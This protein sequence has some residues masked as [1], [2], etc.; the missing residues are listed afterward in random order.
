MKMGGATHVGRVVRDGSQVGHRA[1]VRG[2]D[3]REHDER[4]HEQQRNDG[5]LDVMPRQAGDL[6]LGIAEFLLV[7]VGKDTHLL[8]LL[9]EEEP[10]L[11]IGVLWP[12]SPAVFIN[13][14]GR[15][16]R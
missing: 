2:L 8:A 4:H 7:L 15:D 12:L 16:E 14:I 9:V 10:I 11:S 6:V 3:G 1:L 13:C 5:H